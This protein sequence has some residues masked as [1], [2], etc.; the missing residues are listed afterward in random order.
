[1]SYVW[2]NGKRLIPA[3]FISINKEINFAG[4]GRPINSNHTLGIRGTLV[5]N[6]GSPSSI[7]WYT[8]G[9]DPSNESFSSNSEM[10]NSLL[11][12]QELLREEFSKSSLELIYHP[13]GQPAITLYPKLRSISFEP[14]NWVIKTNYE[15]S[16]DTARIHRSGSLDDDSFGYEIS[17]LFLTNIND[18]WSINE[19]DDGTNS[20]EVNRTISATANTAYYGTGVQTTGNIYGIEA[21]KNAKRW[22]DWRLANVP[23]IYGDSNLGLP[24]TGDFY[25]LIRTENIGKYDGSYS[26]NLRYLFSSGNYTETRQVSRTY[27]YNTVDNQGPSVVRIGI[28]GTIQGLD[29]SN[30]SANKLNNARTYWN[31]IEGGLAT[32][33]GA[34]G[35]LLNKSVNED[36]SAGSI[37]YS[38]S[39]NNISG[40]FYKHDYTASYTIGN[41]G[42]PQ[43]TIQGNIEGYL[44]DGFATN[45]NQHKFHNALSGW[46]IVSPNLKSLAFAYTQIFPTGHYYSNTP[47][48]K[49]LTFDKPNGT[50][51]YNYTFGFAGSGNYANNYTDE[52]QISIE[53]PNSPAN[54][55]NAGLLVTASINGTIAGLA[56][57]SYPE[58]IDLRYANARAAWNNTIRHLL[59]DRVNNEVSLIGSGPALH[60]GFVTR[61]LSTN[62]YGGTIS[63]NASFNNFKAPT[64]ASV[65]IEDVKVDYKNGNDIFAVQVIPGLSSGPI[66]QKFNTRNENQINI[67]VALTLYPSGG[68]WWGIG[69][70]IPANYASGLITGYLP[71]GTRNVNWVIASDTESWD[72]KNGLY[73]KAISIVY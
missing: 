12:K 9:G 72:P 34:S 14:D 8:G 70:Y 11:I 71:T 65:A 30:N 54:A 26:L 35:Q 51:S 10:F 23:I 1:M 61:G 45:G 62:K 58:D 2:I 44:V 6:R 24:A 73:N 46:A 50:L 20:K 5:P 68:S 27:E 19:R 43:V 37:Q 56:D 57:S 18:S 7:G 49:S 55:S 53:S 42:I 69:R 22:V 36:I 31:S 21:W 16:L 40:N 17:G 60:S 3:P 32:Y 66:I 63:Y 48:S 38:L 52:Y 25:N 29:T 41:Q 4:D 13:T 39:Y 64:N 33:I 47:I 67:N 15:I 59:F 28:N